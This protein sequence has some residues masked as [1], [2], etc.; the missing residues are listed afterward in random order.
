LTNGRGVILN[1]VL[2][3]QVMT[4]LLLVLTLL[5]GVAEGQQLSI[6]RLLLS[7]TQAPT[8]LP[9]ARPTFELPPSDKKAKTPG[10]AI[11]LGVGIPVQKVVIYACMFTLS[12]PHIIY[13]QLYSTP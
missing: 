5:F 12:F 3:M 13:H 10:I 2:A 1:V 9:T 8:Q 4:A 6:R 11:G 7:P